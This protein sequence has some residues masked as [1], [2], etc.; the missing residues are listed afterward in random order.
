MGAP[1]AIWLGALAHV[2]VAVR[3]ELVE[4]FE[5]AEVESIVSR[6]KT[7]LEREVPGP[8][9]IDPKIGE[10]C[11]ERSTC[12]LDVLQR[13]GAEEVVLLRVIR[14]VTKI[15]LSAERVR[16]H[17]VGSI[18]AEAT[19][20]PELGQQTEAIDKLVGELYPKTAVP[21]G[22]RLEVA[23]TVP[24]ARLDAEPQGVP[25]LPLVGLAAGL[26]A[27][28]TGAG[29]W[30]GARNTEDDLRTRLAIRDSNGLISGVSLQGAQDRESSINR[31][32]NLSAV[33]GVAGGVL[34]AAD[35]IWFLYLT[36][37]EGSER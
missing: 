21:A 4:G 11:D 24:K 27:V 9:V 28:G 17:T 6:L 22:P 32:R 18:V 12:L 2:S 13:T 34:I 16:P 26:A 3:V 33:F 25:I 8:V 7:S 15:G 20:Y 31:Q 5:R 10:A 19:L 14:V 23:E 37:Q 35:L 1:L 30:I 36:R 29:L